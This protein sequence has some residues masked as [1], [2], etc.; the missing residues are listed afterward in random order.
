MHLLSPCQ[1]SEGW[2]ELCCSLTF[3]VY[4]RLYSD[5]NFHIHC[6][7]FIRLVWCFV[8]GPC[9]VVLGVLSSWAITWLR[10]RVCCSRSI[11]LWLSVFYVFS[12]WLRGWSTVSDCGI[13]WTYLHFG[14]SVRHNK[15]MCHAYDL[16]LYV[17]VMVTGQDQTNFWSMEHTMQIPLS[18]FISLVEGV[19][20]NQWTC[21][22]YKNMY[23]Q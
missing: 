1:R 12:S 6:F 16:D 3:T 10:K 8:L 9:G 13:S 14:T 20:H 18:I 22:E 11:E 2:F 17:K 23:I 4:S 7:V 21:R 5:Q 19:Q 15:T